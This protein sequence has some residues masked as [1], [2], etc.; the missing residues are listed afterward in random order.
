MRTRRSPRNQERLFRELFEPKT[1][2]PPEPPPLEEEIARLRA[3]IEAFA[4]ARPKHPQKVDRARLALLEARL[5]VR[6]MNPA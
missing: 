1:T 6:R 5:R 4:R 2:P 3:R